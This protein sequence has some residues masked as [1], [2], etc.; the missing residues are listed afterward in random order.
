MVRL[1]RRYATKLIGIGLGTSLANSITP[2]ALFAQTRA[3]VSIGTAGKGGFFY[4]LGI[5]IATAI[6]K[7]TS[8]I[9]ATAQVTGGA[10]ENMKLLHEGKIDVALAQADVAWSAAR[11]NSGLPSRFPCA[12]YVGCVGIHASRDAREPR[13]PTALPTSK[14]NV[15][16][17][18][19]REPE[20]QS[21]LC[22]FSMPAA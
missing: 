21:K 19:C 22:A 6:S 12:P 20:R 9:E 8:G 7:Y 17:A 10:A 3:R 13:D 2:G 14:A 4:P 15:Y 1:T 11:E 5:G 18:D 16:P